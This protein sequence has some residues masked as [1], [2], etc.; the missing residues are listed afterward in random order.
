MSGDH[1]E[2]GP[3]PC[4]HRGD[5]PRRERA[6]RPALRG[7]ASR[8]RDAVRLPAGPL[9]RRHRGRRGAGRLGSALS[10]DE[11]RAMADVLDD[12]ARALRG[13]L[14]AEDD[15]A[16]YRLAAAVAAYAPEAFTTLPFG[17]QEPP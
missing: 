8:P 7:R 3:G 16:D 15:A 2:P 9:V 10:G 13:N 12:V 5:G 11:E 17:P 1:H 14:T 4:V 6:V